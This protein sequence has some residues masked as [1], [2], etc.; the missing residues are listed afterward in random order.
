MHIP[1]GFLTAGASVALGVVAAG[2]VAVALR[3][4]RREASEH[5]APLAGLVASFVFAAQMVNFP[6]ALGTSGHLLGGA[7]A[8]ALVGPW[9][10]MLC[11]TVVLVVQAFLFAD[12]GVTALGANVVLLALVGVAVAWLVQQA[13][14][15]VLPS[16]L[17]SVQVAVA[18]SAFVSVVTTAAV[19]AGIFAVGGAVD[20]PVGPL[21]GAMVG[22]HA[23]I[24]V[25]EALITALVVGSVS[26]LRPDL[27]YV[28]RPVLASRP[29]EVSEGAVA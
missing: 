19:F 9:M 20:V 3:G 18:V 22:V 5:A 1:D 2:G 13:L 12:G 16:R 15:R 21:F 29:L 25:G 26:A 11:V 24:G 27:V 28:A 4:C 6:V 7:L 23:L 17:G 10:A 8:A 14:L